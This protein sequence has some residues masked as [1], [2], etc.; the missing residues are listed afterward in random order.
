MRNGD[1]ENFPNGMYWVTSLCGFG[2]N[3]VDFG[4]GKPTG[5]SHAV[6]SANAK[7]IVLMD[8]VDDDGIEAMFAWNNLSPSKMF[9]WI[10]NFE[11]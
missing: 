5:T 10:W 4:W 11:D 9:A 1:L 8:T 7:A 2:F 3:K 6:R